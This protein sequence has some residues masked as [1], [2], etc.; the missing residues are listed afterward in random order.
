M[1]RLFTVRVWTKRALILSLLVNT[2]TL[3]FWFL[4]VRLAAIYLKNA[5][6]SSV[7]LPSLARLH[8]QKTSGLLLGTC[9]NDVG[10]AFF[11]APSREQ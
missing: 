10:M 4:R 2:L 7:N 11:P 6:G 8:I 9:T 1:A 3:S 5:M